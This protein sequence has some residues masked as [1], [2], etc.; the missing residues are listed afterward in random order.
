[1]AIPKKTSQN[2]CVKS[3]ANIIKSNLNNRRNDGVNMK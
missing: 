3:G 1:M 2:C